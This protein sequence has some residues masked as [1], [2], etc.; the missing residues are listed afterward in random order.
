MRLIDADA[1]KEQIEDFH[2]KDCDNYNFVRCRACHIDDAITYLDE[3]PTIG[4]WISVKDRMPENADHPGAF[5]PR[6]QVMTNYCMTEVLY[7]PDKVCWYTLCLF[8]IG[9]Y[10]EDDIDM[11]CG[12]IPRIT[13]KLEVTHWMPLP[14]RPKE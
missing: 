13:N 4:R 11:V 3:A 6:Y 9:R 7:N 2:C 14:E 5:C 12:D 10:D 1:L 8:L